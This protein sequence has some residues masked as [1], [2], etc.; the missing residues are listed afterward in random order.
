MAALH[1][2]FAFSG[3]QKAVEIIYKPVVFL[4]ENRIEPFSSV[5]RWYIGLFR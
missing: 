1:K 5:M 3:F 2:V 4:V